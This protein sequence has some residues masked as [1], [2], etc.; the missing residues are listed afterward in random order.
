MS[1]SRKF[2]KNQNFLHS[3]L[4]TALSDIFDIKYM[5]Q[6]N[7]HHLKF[8]LSSNEAKLLSYH[9]ALVVAALVFFREEVAAV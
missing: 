3:I 4:Y 5:H 8:N 7:D 2:T 6:N 9:S 1:V